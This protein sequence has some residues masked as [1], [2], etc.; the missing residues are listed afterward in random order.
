MKHKFQTAVI[1]EK[2]IPTENTHQK[3]KKGEICNTECDR[4]DCDT[5]NYV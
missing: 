4:A 2:S 3:K 5:Q 1:R